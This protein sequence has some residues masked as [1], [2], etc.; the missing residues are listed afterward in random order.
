MVF[1][2]DTMRPG[3]FIQTSVRPRGG[4]AGRR[5]G[6]A[7]VGRASGGEGAPVRVESL[8]DLE[9][10]GAGS[11]LQE[12]GRVL[13]EAGVSP[14]WAAAAGEDYAAA[15]AGLEALEGVG[16]VAA[17]GG[18][19]ALAA[20]V[21]SCAGAGRERVGLLAVP[22]PE[23]A[24]REAAALDCERVAVV[25]DGG[26]ATH[27]TAAALAAVA[28]C[29]GA[30]ASLN[31]AQLPLGEFGGALAP[32]Q[33]E[34]LLKAGV[35]P[36]ERAGDEAVCVRA[37]TTRQNDRALADLSTVLAADE[38]VG[39]VR[40]AVQGRLRG[41]RNSGVTRESVASQALVE[42]EALRA[43]GVIDGYAAPTVEPHPQDPAVC[44][45]TLAFRV[46]PELSQIVLA[47]E[48]T[49]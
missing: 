33:S 20:H 4:A 32:A 25:C 38:V 41:L 2:P 22:G 16:V 37:V 23:Q 17:D 10:F 40:A 28:A 19:A 43:L 1:L 45:V 26:S 42:L 14:L 31:G 39:A 29:A 6:V 44:V 15:F 34:A 24:A 49:V 12:M 46:A 7:I 21:R 13:L 18:G 35:T 30:G 3:V 5:R 48:I 11:A 36:V 27:R 8:A 47:A 9:A